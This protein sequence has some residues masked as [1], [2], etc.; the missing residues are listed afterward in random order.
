MAQGKSCDLLSPMDEGGLCE[1]SEKVLGIFVCPNISEGCLCERH[2]K[3]R[4][5]L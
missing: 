1:P 2:E 3:V 5:S 4:V